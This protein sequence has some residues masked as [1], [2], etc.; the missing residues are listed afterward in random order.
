MPG[1]SLDIAKSKLEAIGVRI[2]GQTSGVGSEH[3]AVCILDGGDSP[4]RLNMTVYDIV[5]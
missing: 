1:A 4:S 2:L 3:G 5:K